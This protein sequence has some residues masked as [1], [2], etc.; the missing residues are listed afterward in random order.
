VA[1]AC[2]AAAVS[3][4]LAAERLGVV[5]GVIPV[6]RDWELAE[7]CLHDEVGRALTRWPL[8]GI[9]DNPSA[10]LAVTA[11]RRA[12]DVLRRRQAEQK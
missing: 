3:L 2:V 6:T 9:P 12:S 4:A 10:W 11:R 7:D 8:D 1:E 5:A